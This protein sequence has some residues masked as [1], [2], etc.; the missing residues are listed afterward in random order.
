M[1]TIDYFLKIAGLEGESADEMHR[2]EIEVQS[3]NW[4]ETQSGTIRPGGGGRPGVSKVEPR[5]FVFVKKLDK[6]SPALFISCATGEH[7][8]N[9]VLAARKAGGGQQDYLTVTMDDL[10]ISSYQVMGVAE[11][12]SVPSDQIALS[13]A[14]LRMSYKPQKSDGSFSGEVTEKY[15]FVANRKV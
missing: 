8:T 6:S 12:G 7:F 1:A 10:L 4:G 5:D 14:K 15:D 3:F 2:G 11:A 9:A 13:F